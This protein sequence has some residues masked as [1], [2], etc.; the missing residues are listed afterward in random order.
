MDR[1]SEAK[2]QK[3]PKKVKCDGRTDGPTDGG[4][5][6]PTDGPT[7]RGVES[8]NTRLKKA[9]TT[10]IDLD[11]QRQTDRHCK[12]GQTKS[13]AFHL[14]DENSLYVCFLRWKKTENRLKLSKICSFRANNAHSGPVA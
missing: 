9:K 1:S 11:R 6:R 12:T 4:T 8:R 3:N 13:L 10:K 7:K 5:D 14:K 2:N